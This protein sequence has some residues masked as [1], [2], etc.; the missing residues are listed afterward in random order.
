MSYGEYSNF[1]NDIKGQHTRGTHKTSPPPESGWIAR[2]REASQ[3]L[4]AVQY[5]RAGYKRGGPH[6][7]SVR[8]SP[9]GVAITCTDSCRIPIQLVDCPGAACVASAAARAR[10]LAL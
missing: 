7:N 1:D 4:V 10:T 6:T 5:E 3:S 9:L 8:T 2:L